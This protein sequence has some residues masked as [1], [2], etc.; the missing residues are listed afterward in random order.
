MAD[1]AWAMGLRFPAYGGVA[2]WFKAP[3]LKTGV[4]LTA[5]REFES[6]PL[7]QFM[8]STTGR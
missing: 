2:E 7:R 1:G 8:P 6:R 3:V 4:R 5:D